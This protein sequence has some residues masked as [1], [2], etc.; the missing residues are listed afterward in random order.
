MPGEAHY[1]VLFSHRIFT[2]TR[3]RR[4]DIQP[5]RM[6]ESLALRVHIAISSQTVH[7]EELCSTYQSDTTSR[8]LYRIYTAHRALPDVE[9]MEDLFNSTALMDLLIT[10]PKRSPKQQIQLWRT[11]KDQRLQTRSILHSLGQQITAAQ[12]KRLISLGLSHDILCEIWASSRGGLFQKEL[13]TR[14]VRSKKLREKLPAVFTT[15]K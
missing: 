7:I 8:A 3:Q 6:F 13:I 4:M 10:V 11:H 5:Y 2:C 14:G 1:D 15:R 12:A 9:A